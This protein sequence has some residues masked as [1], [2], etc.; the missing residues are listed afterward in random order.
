VVI[1]PTN[2]DVHEVAPGDLSY[3]VAPGG[4]WRVRGGVVY[5]RPAAVF[6][7]DATCALRGRLTIGSNRPGDYSLIIESDWAVQL[8]PAI[9]EA[10]TQPPLAPDSRLACVASSPVVTST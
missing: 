1:V 5:D 3:L 2:D 7:F 9:N 4:T 8:Q 6:I 10:A